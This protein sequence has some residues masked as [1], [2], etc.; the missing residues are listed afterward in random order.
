MSTIY[1]PAKR[2]IRLFWAENP[3]M[4]EKI[5]AEAGKLKP[6]WRTFSKV[7]WMKVIATNIISTSRTHSMTSNWVYIRRACR[8]VNEMG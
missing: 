1:I 8:I 5:Q 3:K 7:R 4:M 6:I 2:V